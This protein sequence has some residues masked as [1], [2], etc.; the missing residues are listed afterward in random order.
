ME[1]R[2]KFSAAIFRRGAKMELF[3]DGQEESAFDEQQELQG[4]LQELHDVWSLPRTGWV[5]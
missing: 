4:K 3:G 5:K 2:E 1:K